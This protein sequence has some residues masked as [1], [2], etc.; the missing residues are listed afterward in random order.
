LVYENIEKLMKEVKNFFDLSDY[1]SAK[2]ALDKVLHLD[3]NDQVAL[4]YEKII[5]R[6]LSI[7]END[8]LIDLEKKKQKMVL[9]ALEMYSKGKKSY[10][11][12]KY[13]QA[14]KFFKNAWQLNPSDSNFS[15]DIQRYI[16]K[17]Y[18]VLNKERDAITE[19]VRK[20]EQEQSTSRYEKAKEF[21]Q[22]GHFEQAVKFFKESLMVDPK[23]PYVKDI[24]LYLSK[25]YKYM[26]ELEKQGQAQELYEE[27]LA[28]QKV[29]ESRKALSLFRQVEKLD[30]RYE[31][32]Q[33]YIKMLEK[34]DA[35]PAPITD[36]NL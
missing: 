21:Y 9:E 30:P 18:A 24:R 32:L 17:T 5:D 15:H 28:F 11:Q 3:P 29:G 35:V 19:K 10:V 6:Y 14:L 12:K 20:E 31:D 8:E 16:E 27:A 4:E 2:V 23:S 25:S 26:E 7:R 22:A 33:L 34:Q 1:P 13:T 36:K